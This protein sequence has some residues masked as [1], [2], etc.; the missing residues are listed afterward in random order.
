MTTS[1]MVSAICFMFTSCLLPLRH[2]VSPLFP[3][4]HNTITIIKWKT[5]QASFASIRAKLELKVKRMNS[6]KD[7]AAEL[8]HK[9][10]FSRTNH[11]FEAL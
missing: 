5:P 3:N 6:R 8:S 2:R 10:A 7:F 4:M 11:Y 9:A 1:V